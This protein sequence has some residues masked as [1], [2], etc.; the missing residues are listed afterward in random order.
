MGVEPRAPWK[1]CDHPLSMAAAPQLEGPFCAPSRIMRN[2]LLWAWKVI[3]SIHQL[4]HS[5]DLVLNNLLFFPQTCFL[6]RTKF[7]TITD[8]Q[9]TKASA[10][11]WSMCLLRVVILT[12]LDTNTRAF[13]MCQ[14][15]PCMTLLSSNN[16]FARQYPHYP[17]GMN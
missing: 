9:R 12:N 6:E 7:L 3:L 1:L 10:P 17:T 13:M 2:M 8:I 11:F 15:S 4:P 5:A 16:N 14:Q